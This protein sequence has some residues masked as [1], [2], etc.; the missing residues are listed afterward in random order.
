[1]AKPAT[2]KTTFMH[3]HPTV[4]DE[5]ILKTWWLMM[6]EGISDGILQSGEDYLIQDGML[7]L[8]FGPLHNA[9]VRRVVEKGLRRELLLS[10]PQMRKLLTC[11]REY[12]YDLRKRM[13][14]DVNVRTMVLLWNK[15]VRLP[16]RKL[17]KVG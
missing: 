11:Q 16:P 7:F 17:R 10:P 1:M 14:E 15:Q 4:F 8:S 9:Y 13:S 5:D 6:E 2:A 3:R 12:L